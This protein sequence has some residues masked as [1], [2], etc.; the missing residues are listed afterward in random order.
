V[1]RRGLV[2]V[3]GNKVI[4]ACLCAGRHL[5]RGFGRLG[6][7][8]FDGGNVIFALLQAERVPFFA[9]PNLAPLAGTCSGLEALVGLRIL[10]DGL[11]S[12]FGEILEVLQAGR[13]VSGQ[14][15]TQDRGRSLERA[16]CQEGETHV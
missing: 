11:E 6:L 12:L 1:D 15:C 4:K 2:D 13:V 9:D 7:E 16:R 5:G 8:A 3:R 10:L 14:Y